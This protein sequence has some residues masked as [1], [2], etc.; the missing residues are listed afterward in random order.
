VLFVFVFV[1]STSLAVR[2]VVRCCVLLC[3]ASAVYRDSRPTRGP[4]EGGGGR[5]GEKGERAPQAKKW[6]F[7]FCGGVLINRIKLVVNR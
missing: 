5:K 7:V 4:G 3:I 6:S 1:L 2:C